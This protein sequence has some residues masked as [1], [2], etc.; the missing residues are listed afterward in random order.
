MS[1]KWNYGDAIERHPI[2]EGESAIFEDGSQLQVHNIFN[3][4]PDF[5]RQADLIFVDPPWNLSNI[6]TFYTKADMQERVESF[7]SFYQRLFECIAEINPKTCY[8]EIGKQYLADFI[9]EMRKIYKYVTFYNNTY[10]HNKN[11]LCYIVRGS[12]KSK[13]PSLDGLDEEKVIEWVCANEEY[14]VVADLCMGRGLVAVNAKKNNKIFVGTE[15]NK[16]RL[17]V[18]I[19]KIVKQDISYKIKRCRGEHNEG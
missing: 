3:P 8:V 16:K 9:V 18:T 15:M 12:N 11:K 1:K 14:D 4:L 5:M 7:E 2:N 10:Y 19:E 13:K 6:N 17:A